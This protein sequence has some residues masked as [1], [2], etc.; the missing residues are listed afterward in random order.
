MSLKGLRDRLDEAISDNHIGTEIE[1]LVVLKRRFDEVEAALVADGWQLE[2]GV[3]F[4]NGGC[5]VKMSKDGLTWSLHHTT[6]QNKSL[7]LVHPE[8]LTVGVPEDALEVLDSM[9]TVNANMISLL[10]TETVPK[11]SNGYF[12][13]DLGGVSTS[14]TDPSFS[15]KLERWVKAGKSVRKRPPTKLEKTHFAIMEMIEDLKDNGWSLLSQPSEG[16]GRYYDHIYSLQKGRL[17]MWIVCRPAG[18]PYAHLGAELVTT[19]RAHLASESFDDISGLIA[20]L[21]ANVPRYEHL[22]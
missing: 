1:R 4:L 14:L 18:A 11:P 20:W 13:V 19:E 3:S 5:S 2:E 10:A 15:Q 22:T 17:V 21:S 6:K 12:S 16:L 7:T 9:D 8:R